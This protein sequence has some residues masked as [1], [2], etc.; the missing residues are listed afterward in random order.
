MENL[1]GPERDYR[2]TA[3][4][5]ETPGENPAGIHMRNEFIF[6]ISNGKFLTLRELQHAM[7]DVIS[8][9]FGAE[10]RMMDKQIVEIFDQRQFKLEATQE[11]ETGNGREELLGKSLGK[12][13]LDMAVRKFR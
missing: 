8:D 4:H 11:F 1:A 12:M 7:N 10:V 2:T 13:P 6:R 3:G 9:T 5:P